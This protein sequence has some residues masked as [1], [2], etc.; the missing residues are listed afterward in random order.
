MPYRMIGDGHYHDMGDFS[1]SHFLYSA[2]TLSVTG[3]SEWGTVDISGIV[4]AEARAVV[5]RYGMRNTSTNIANFTL[6]PYGYSNGGHTLQC[7]Q[8][9]TSLWRNE[10]GILPVVDGKLQYQLPYAWTDLEAWIVIQ[11]YFT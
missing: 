4:P 8:Q 11:G 9:V 2:G 5:L 1:G 3:W 6:R 10:N 7:Y